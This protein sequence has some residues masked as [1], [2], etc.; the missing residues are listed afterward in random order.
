MQIVSWSI[1]SYF[2]DKIWKILQN[3][4]CWVFYPAGLALISDAQSLDI[5]KDSEFLQFVT[6]CN[7]QFQRKPAMQNGGRKRMRETCRIKATW[8]TSLLTRASALGT[9]W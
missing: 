4:V 9:Q 6:A 3:A 2:L 7:E 1:K 8:L 5:K